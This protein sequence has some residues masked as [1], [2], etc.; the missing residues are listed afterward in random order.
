MQDP[1]QGQVGGRDVFSDVSRSRGSKKLGLSA[2][3][4]AEGVKPG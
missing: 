2:M 4:G 3:E 1:E